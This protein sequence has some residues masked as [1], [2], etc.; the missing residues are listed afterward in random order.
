MMS[1]WCKKWLPWR[2]ARVLFAAE[3]IGSIKRLWNDSD[4]YASHWNLYN[5]EL[6]DEVLQLIKEINAEVVADLSAAVFC[7]SMRDENLSFDD[8]GVT[9]RAAEDLEVYDKFM[10]HPLVAE[11]PAILFVKK[12]NSMPM[13]ADSLTD[14]GFSLYTD[15]SSGSRFMAEELL[16]ATT[17]N[18]VRMDHG[19]QYTSACSVLIALIAEKDLIIEM[20]AVEAHRWRN[21]IKVG[22][23]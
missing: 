10:N 8:V 18:A 9:D 5:V 4:F 23:L 11:L 16:T 6:K 15:Y 19:N 21:G 13:G 3:L 12:A 17:N 22:R 7:T 1:K 20:K 14:L 2:N